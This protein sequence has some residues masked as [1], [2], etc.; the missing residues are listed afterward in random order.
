[1]T[2]AMTMNV[3]LEN[4]HW[5]PFPEKEFPEMDI[6][7]F[8]VSVF[9]AWVVFR[10]YREIGNICRRF[11]DFRD[12]NRHKVSSV[13]GRSVHHGDSLFFLLSVLA[14]VWWV[15]I[16]W[17]YSGCLDSGE[18]FI[19][20]GNNL[21][22]LR[23]CLF[24]LTFYAVKWVVLRMVSVVFAEKK[25]G[26]FVW[27]TGVYH[28]MPFSLIALPLLLCSVYMENTGKGIVLWIT[29]ALLLMFFI[30]KILKSVMVGKNYSRFSYLHIFVYF[31]ALEILSFTILWQMFFYPL[32]V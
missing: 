25:F 26:I 28:D 21:L 30:V 18:G 11:F 16:F 13:K 22:L 7:V 24:A 20:Q 3:G 2:E 10:Q 17:Q 27:K 31:C 4:L 1:M 8:V 9:F 5:M 32:A 12:S 19:C 23:C 6:W 14:L 15:Y 29:G